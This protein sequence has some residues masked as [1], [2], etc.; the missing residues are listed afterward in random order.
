MNLLAPQNL[1]LVAIYGFATRFVPI[2]IWP[3]PGLFC[4]Q[5]R[6]KVCTFQNMAETRPLLF[7]D[8]PQGLYF[9][10]YGRNPAPFVYRF[11]TMFVLFKIWPKP[12]LFCLCKS[13]LSTNIEPNLTVNGKSIDGVFGIWAWD[14]MMVAADESTEL[15]Q[16]F[17]AYFF[18]NYLNIARAFIASVPYT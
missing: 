15:W 3:K 11:A 8:S 10:K 1:R 6:H 13:F 5:I 18:S 2:K 16:G 17:A 4:L 12:G 9:S 7:T 14:H